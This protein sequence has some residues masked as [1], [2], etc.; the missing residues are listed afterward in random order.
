[1]KKAQNKPVVMDATGKGDMDASGRG[2]FLRHTRHQC[3]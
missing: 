1:M 3:C 2:S